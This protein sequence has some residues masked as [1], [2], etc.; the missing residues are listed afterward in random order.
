MLLDTSSY[1]GA[2][3]F[4]QVKFFVKNFI[5]YFHLTR[6]GLN[7]FIGFVPYSDRVI[8][9]KMINFRYS[10]S[11]R[12]LKGKVDEIPYDGSSGFGLD[13]ALKYARDTLFTRFKGSRSWVPRVVLVITASARDWNSNQKNAI[14]REAE[15]LKKTG[16]QLMIVSIGPVSSNDGFLRSIVDSKDHLH[17]VL[18]PYLLY[19]ISKKLTNQICPEPSKYL[20]TT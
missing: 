7:P 11:A 17:T 18:F 3:N 6:S 16:S 15:R 10:T 1:V 19:E 5:D 2:N 14:Q 4:M 20:S 9:N 12:R 13:L 8:K